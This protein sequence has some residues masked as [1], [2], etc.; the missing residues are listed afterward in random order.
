MKRLGLLALAL[1]AAVSF[2]S[3]GQRFWNQLYRLSGFGGKT[4]APFDIHVMDV[5]KADA[6]LLE[7]EGHAALLD[8][9]T[10]AH[11]EAVVDYLIRHGVEKLD[12]AIV[13]HP[14]KDHLGG[15]EQVLREVPCGQLIRSPYFSEQY[16]EVKRTA[17][18]KG[19]PIH[20]AT[21]GNV[22]E[23]GSAK[24]RILGP[25]RPYEDTND[26]SLVVS[27]RY[28]DFSA[29][30]CGDIEEG[31]EQDLVESGASL[32]ADLLKVP[33]HGSETSCSESFL[34][35]VDPEYAV[36]SVGRDRNHLP[37]EKVMK[38]LD[39]ICTDVFRTDTDGAVVFLYGKNGLEIE[40][41]KGLRW[42]NQ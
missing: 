7:C 12:Y 1:L 38:R 8:A 4:E 31:A 9:G 30:F 33:H 22:F 40:T 24:L 23:L 42:G 39:E 21:P 34:K 25:C 5:D 19:V 32:K 3:S 2:T 11:G 29:L 6:I 14:D 37:S 18:Q 17:D 16:K 15:M 28:R 27:L 13:S 26:A 35:A 36:V 41:E 20:L 10:A